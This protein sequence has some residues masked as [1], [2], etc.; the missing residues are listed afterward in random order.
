MNAEE[1]LEALS[2]IRNMMERSSRF[3][4]LNGLAGVF[5]GLFALAGAWG[6]Y[7]YLGMQGGSDAYYEY[8]RTANGD[9]NLSFYEFFFA[10]A[11][12]VLVLSVLVS[13][14]MTLCKARKAGQT[15]WGPTAKRLFLNMMIPLMSGGV[16]CLIMV[17]HNTAAMVAPA[18]LIFYGL[19]LV[20]ASKYTFD[21][22]RH[23]GLIE[24]V[25][26]LLAAVYIRHGLLF[27]SLG[28]G[29]MHI[30]Y[31]IVMY[32]KYEAKKG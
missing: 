22:V 6:A 18:M 20:N 21:D 7:M 10:D 17:Y 11:I 4:S 29:V 2:D 19:A 14:L 23:L 27:W 15:V 16:F 12:S 28:F 1:H 25:L 3:V 9:A 31:G 30:I 26:G 13:T 32:Y 5:V 8:A 24:I